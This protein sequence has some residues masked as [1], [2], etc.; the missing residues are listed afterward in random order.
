M[1]RLPTQ[2]DH[3]GRERTRHTEGAVTGYRGSRG[4]T[5]TGAAIRPD[6]SHEG[7][8]SSGSHGVYLD[9]VQNVHDT[10]CPIRRQ[11]RALAMTSDARRPLPEGVRARRRLAAARL[12]RRSATLTLLSTIFPGAGLTQ[13]RYYRLGWIIVT[14]T[15][16]LT[17]A[18]AA[19]VFA[20]GPTA[21]ALAVAVRPGALLVVAVLMLLGGL[22]WVWS[23]WLTH[24]G[25]VDDRL[26]RV[27][28]FSLKALAAFLCLV[29]AI[30]MA[31]A[32]RYSLIQRDVI[33]S[34]FTQ[35]ATNADPNS[36]AARPGTGADPWSDS[37]RVNVLLLGSDAG[38]DRVGVRTDSM[39]V[40]SIDTQ[41]GETVLFSLPR[42]LQ[43][44]PFPSSNPLSKVYPKGYTCGSECLLNAVWSL[45]ADPAYGS[46]FPG[47][48][49]PGLYTTR[50]VIGEILGL[51]IDS[52]VI[53]DLQG[54]Q[55]LIDA[56]GGVTVNVT[57]RL[58]VE[59]H[60]NG[61]GGVVGVQSWIE[62][63]VQHLDGYHA[64]WFARSRALS[65]DFSRMRRQRCLVGK[66]IEQVNP[67]NML[68]R[69]PALAQVA[70]DNIQTD[71][72]A[73][74]LP[75]WV[76]LVQRVKNGNIRSLA[77]TPANVNV[78]NPNFATIRRM[79]QEAL[80]PVP[81][82]TVNEA[83]APTTDSTPSTSTSKGGKTTSTKSAVTATT[84]TAPATAAVTIDEAC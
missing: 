40:A 41:T 22:L 47:I 14:L 13:T 58:P 66:I 77:F 60:S 53:V 83:P 64:L 59:G 62:P 18:V 84:S 30:P 28:R 54:F 72:S 32:V 6:E 74:D 1:R 16:G 38:D 39:I 82:A 55:A 17:A 73:G 8:T 31:T 26:D 29:V 65:D 9:E 4:R 12:A 75:A 11:G 5:K 52:Y 2:P 43:N 37:P 50:G 24:Q 48:T 51:R 23:I 34:L 70:K 61:Y 20:K 33:S 21:P 42:N 69:Y 81:T 49:N 27:Q 35:D 78:G 3:R 71:I 57:E 68:Q 7:A 25:S 44:V 56:M 67:Q 63:G 10:I 80:R 46:K 19:V 15:A 45:A 79:V 76:D 36:P